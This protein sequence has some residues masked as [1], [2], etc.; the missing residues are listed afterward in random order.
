[1]IFHLVRLELCLRNSNLRF[2]WANN[3]IMLDNFYHT[4]DGVAEGTVIKTQLLY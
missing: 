2:K 4:R 3:V 1:M